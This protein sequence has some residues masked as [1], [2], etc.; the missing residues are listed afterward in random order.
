MQHEGC[1]QSV[2]SS[3]DS[4]MHFENIQAREI[5]GRRADNIQHKRTL[6]KYFF[7]LIKHSLV[8]AHGVYIIGYFKCASVFREIIYNLHSQQNWWWSCTKFSIWLIKFISLGYMQC[9]EYFHCKV[10]W[11]CAHLHDATPSFAINIVLFPRPKGYKYFF[12]SFNINVYIIWHY[13][14]YYYLVRFSRRNCCQTMP[15]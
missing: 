2:A 9:S 10:S 15:W 13:A 12:S 8:H 14:Y 1:L 7:F 5:V 4:W 3:A 11:L 6:G